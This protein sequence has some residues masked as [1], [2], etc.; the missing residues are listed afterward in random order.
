MSIFAIIVSGILS[1]SGIWS[2]NGENDGQWD[3]I[4]PLLANEGY[5]T[6]FYLAAYGP[7]LFEEGLQEC[8]DACRPLGID[9]HAWVVMWRTDYSPELMDRGELTPEDM[10][11]YSDG[12]MVD[13]WM[14]P[15][16]PSN[17]QGMASVCLDLAARY[18]VEGIHLDYI[19]YKYYLSGYSQRNLREFTAHLGIRG[20]VTAEECVRDG[21]YYD[22]FMRW[23]ANTITDAVRAVRDSLGRINRVV[24]LSAAVFPHE[25][26]MLLFG[27]LW[28]QWLDTG[29]VDFVVPMNYTE[30]DSQFTVWGEEQLPLAEDHTILCGIGYRSHASE[31]SP[32]EMEAQI[33]AAGEMGFD[34]YVI[35][36]LCSDLLADMQPVHDRHDGV[37]P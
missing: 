34:G 19:R 36:R 35:Y 2:R 14:N 25:R 18:P 7:A 28:N 8:L 13:N 12:E 21:R 32:S 30:S 16:V 31:L 5:D 17:V 26:E 15:A 33:Q 1:I 3:T 10:Q 22:E 20:C 23:R 27:Q 29:L 9:V 6:V 11:Y 24:Q 4:A 37:G